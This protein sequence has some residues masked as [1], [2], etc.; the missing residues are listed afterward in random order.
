MTPERW[1]QI[2]AL[3]QAALD[4][5]PAKRVAFLTEACGDDDELRREVETLLGFH[6]RAENFIEAPPAEMA[7]DWLAVKESRVGQT[8]GRYQLIREIG[9]GGMGEVYLAHDSQ[10]RR[11]V[12]LKLLPERFTQDPERVRRFRH[13]AR[14]VSSLN[15]PNILTIYEVAETKGVHYLATEYVVGQTL[16]ALLEAKQLTLGATLDI[17]IQVGEALAASHHAGIIH[18]DIKPENLMQRADGYVKVLDFGLAKLAETPVIN[19]YDTNPYS[20][21]H[22]RPGVVLGTARYMSPEQARG[23]EVDARTDVFSLGCV[24]YEMLTGR[25]P[26]AG[27]TPSDVIAALLEHEPRPLDAYGK[28]LPAELQRI[29]QRALQKQRNHRYADISAML[30]DLRA[31]KQQLELSANLPRASDEPDPF[32]MRVGVASAGLDQSQ[33]ETWQTHQTPVR[34]TAKIKTAFAW[35]KSQRRYVLAALLIIMSLLGF[36][37]LYRIGGLTLV[38][39]GNE[40]GVKWDDEQPSIAVLPFTDDT[41]DAQLNYLSDGLTESLSHS[42]TRLPGLRVVAGAS[43]FSYKGHPAN[44]LQAGQD[45]KVRVIVNGRVQELQDKLIVNVELADTRDGARLWGQQYQR[46][47]A[48]L[49]TLQSDIVRDLTQQMRL[50]VS[51]PERAAAS[52]GPTNDPEAYRL[53]LSG[54]YQ[55]NKRSPEGLFKSLELFRQATEKDPGYALA[56]ASLAGSYITLASYHLRPPTEVLPLARE[57]AAQAI[58]IDD[59]LA[60]AHA[61]MGRVINDYYW[62]WPQAEQEFQRAL[63]LN[64][65]TATTHVWYSAFLTNVGRFD[66]ALREAQRAQELDPLSPVA[67]TNLGITLYRARRYDQAITV[68]QNILSR[69]PNFVTARI[70]LGLCYRLQGQPEAARAEFLK[71]LLVMPDNPS[72]IG[73]YGN[74]CGLAGHRDE[75]RQRLAQLNEMAKHGYVP[76]LAQAGI[77]NGLGDINANYAWLEK[78]LAERSPFLSGLKTD[79]MFDS[80]RADPRYASFLRRVGF[81]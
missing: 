67:N 7:A 65:H 13:E 28:S 70:Y 43:V 8:M 80:I 10:L 81:K 74:A 64:P 25:V 50:R 24:L 31:L 71:G 37:W 23:E 17:A 58:Q 32:A 1:Q 33:R 69:E 3:M 5:E 11:Q 27:E 51:A 45:L 14:A 73:M 52:Q 9:R 38:L 42:L 12:A 21:L 75:A 79:P 56:Y 40:V 18:R 15:H 20:L 72:L 68:L 39:K 19:N 57:A 78:S 41:H 54:S 16:R 47:V 53:Y 49:L 6:E 61:A 30:G 29:V 35:V 26:F 60:E 22:T 2:D 36:R 59:Q 34:T 44:P 48:E 66:E 46:P 77:V 55:W 4:Y 62:E 76:P 63:A